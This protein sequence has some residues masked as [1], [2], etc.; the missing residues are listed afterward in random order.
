MGASARGPALGVFGPSQDGALRA[1][2][3]PA[4]QQF[5]T[6]QL[7]AL[8]LPPEEWAGD[9]SSCPVESESI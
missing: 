7:N 9:V 1:P 6:R 3:T 5:L 4:G 2:S 8:A